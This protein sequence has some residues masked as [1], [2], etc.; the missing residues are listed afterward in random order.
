MIRDGEP[1]IIDMGDFSRGSYLFDV[2]L[3]CT[4]YGVPELGISELATKI[5]TAMGL[6]LWDRFVVHYFAD[7]T[8]EEYAYFVEHRDFLASLRLI[9]TITFLPTMREACVQMIRDTLM[10]RIRAAA[11]TALS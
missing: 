2:G 8:P 11:P 3:L 4:I 1:V 9:Y 7:K 6:E 10:P 5:P